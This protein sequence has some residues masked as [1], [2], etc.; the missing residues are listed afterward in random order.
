MAKLDEDKLDYFPLYVDKLIADTFDMSTMEFGAYMRLLLKAWKEKNVG[1]LPNEDDQ[2][3]RF[4]GLNA[5]QWATVKAV[6]L[7][8]F[9]DLN[10]PRIVQKK[11]KQVHREVRE[12][13]KSRKDHARAAALA[14][15]KKKKD[16]RAMPEHM[17]EQSPSNA[18]KT[19]TETEIKTE[20]KNRLFGGGE[21]KAIPTPGDDAL[22]DQ[23]REYIS[24]HRFLNYHSAAHSDLRDTVIAVGWD[25]A[26]EFVEQA[27]G[28]GI[29][30]PCAY[31]A[32][33]ARNDTKSQ[34]AK[35]HSRPLAARAND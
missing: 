12:L 11:M 8:R 27:I 20:T 26:R 7:A 22:D 2:L 17:P 32:G 24:G 30:F 14:K 1:T 4:A 10:K 31:A 29:S 35:R 23:I 18:I 13:V 33:C 19:E 21:V 16:A 15:W 34:A 9:K 5:E 3:A 28:K 25:K 6:V